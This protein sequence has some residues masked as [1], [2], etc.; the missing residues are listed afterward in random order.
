M[1]TSRKNARKTRGRPFEIGNPGRP[2][3][4]R[5]KATLAVE[6]IL[7]GE[8]EVLTRKAVER[9]LEGDIQ[10]LKLCLERLLPPRRERLVGLRLRPIKCATDAATAGSAIIAAVACGDLSVGEASGLM[11]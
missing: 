3:G 11:H 2:K 4:S 9:A 1:V 8:A 6:A 7:E 10:A 5:N